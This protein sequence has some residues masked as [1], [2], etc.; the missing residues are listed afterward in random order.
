MSEKEE[1]KRARSWIDEILSSDNLT[2]EAI[3]KRVVGRVS[4][5]LKSPRQSLY[6]VVIFYQLLLLKNKKL[7]KVSR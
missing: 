7:V 5:L 2:L 6:L 1:K 4:L 3:L